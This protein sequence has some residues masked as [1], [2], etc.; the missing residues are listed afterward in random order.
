MT[1]LFDQT[2]WKMALAFTAGLLIAGVLGGIIA[3]T[4]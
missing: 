4:V 3:R 2:F 1:G